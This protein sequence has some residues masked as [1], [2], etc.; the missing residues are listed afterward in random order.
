[1]IGRQVRLQGGLRDAQALLQVADRSS[2]G[3]FADTAFEY[4]RHAFQDNQLGLVVGKGGGGTVEDHS[5]R[6]A[7]QRLLNFDDH[8]RSIVGDAGDAVEVGVNI[9][10]NDGQIHN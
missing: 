10:L 3:R 1:M 6:E 7:A 5:R 4:F 9:V 8:G 2:S